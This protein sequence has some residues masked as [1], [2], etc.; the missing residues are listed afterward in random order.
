MY[1]CVSAITTKEKAY[2]SISCLRSAFKLTF[3]V[4][5]DMTVCRSLYYYCITNSIT[6][7]IIIII[8][9]NV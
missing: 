8:L 4:S 6:I 9:I 2:I 5:Y 1:R 7:I 3:I